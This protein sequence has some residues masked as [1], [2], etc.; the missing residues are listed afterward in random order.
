[1]CLIILYNFFGTHLYWI[2]LKS[3][4]DL[5]WVTS[6]KLGASLNVWDHTDF[7]V[8][9]WYLGKSKH[10]LRQCWGF[11]NYCPLNLIV[12]VWDVKEI[13]LVIFLSSGCVCMCLLAVLHARSGF[14][15]ITPVCVCVCVCVCVWW[16]WCCLWKQTGD[17]QL[18]AF[19]VQRVLSMLALLP[20]SIRS[21]S[22]YGSEPLRPVSH[23]LR[24]KCD[25]NSNVCD[26]KQML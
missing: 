9:I 6:Y 10:C 12:V 4:I 20:K 18:I 7:C 11:F 26:I 2:Q 5:N 15:F 23:I 3:N 19:T 13:S 1:M 24:G 8:Q 22:T 17:V 25:N 14:S 16:W 21:H